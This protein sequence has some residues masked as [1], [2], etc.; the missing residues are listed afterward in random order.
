MHQQHA[1]VT[2]KI[3]FWPQHPLGCLETGT[4]YGV[5]GWASDGAIGHG[6]QP[7]SGLGGQILALRILG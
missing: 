2:L 1:V 7:C 4:A 3:L 6:M 5:F